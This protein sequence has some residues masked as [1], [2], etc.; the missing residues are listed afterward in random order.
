MALKNLEIMRTPYDS[1]SRGSTIGIVFG[2]DS[3]TAAAPDGNKAGVSHI[4]L[5]NV[6]VWGFYKGVEY[7]A[8]SCITR[9]Y[10]VDIFRCT[11]GI[12]KV[13][14]DNAGENYSYF[15][16]T[17]Y[18]NTHGIYTEEGDF[19]FFGTSFD[20]MTSSYIWAKG[21]GQVFLNSCFIERRDKVNLPTQFIA[22]DTGII[23]IN[24]TRFTIEFL[25]DATVKLFKST[26]VG[27]AGIVI[28][29]SFYSVKAFRSDG[30]QIGTPT[31]NVT[32]IDGSGVVDFQNTRSF[33]TSDYNH[34]F[35][36]EAS[37]TNRKSIDLEITGSNGTITGRYTSP[38]TTITQ[39]LTTFESGTFSYKIDKT[40]AA[41]ITSTVRIY[42]PLKKNSTGKV[43]WRIR[44]QK[45]NGAGFTQ[46]Q[47]WA[48]VIPFG[49][50]NTYNQSLT[51]SDGSTVQVP[52]TFRTHFVT[53]TAPITG[54]STSIAF[55]TGSWSWGVQYNTGTTSVRPM[56]AN[57]YIIDFD[58]TSIGAITLFL[59]RIEFFE[60]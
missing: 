51:A 38:N 12:Y 16:G 60:F 11:Y 48:S 32:M 45:V 47:S 14:Y 29:D 56:W 54:G 24:N 7:R 50:D 2:E 57:Y 35:L 53:K 41:G 52:T 46:T 8:N 27:S 21:G 36:N 6:S 44:G 40:T 15:G 4:N 23:V 43:G 1:A 13:Q 25:N 31:E 26:G 22:E 19:H 5:E 30:T 39:D 9:H 55:N 17:I 58:L 59:D 3:P 28:R 34:Y 49:K 18:N 10:G 37:S 33:D 20:Y 42:V